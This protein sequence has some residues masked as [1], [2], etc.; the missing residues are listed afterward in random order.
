MNKIILFL[1]VGALAFSSCKPKYRICEK[2]DSP[3]SPNVVY[4]VDTNVIKDGKADLYLKCKNSSLHQSN[5][6][7]GESVKL[8]FDSVTK[9]TMIDGGYQ[10]DICPYYRADYCSDCPALGKKENIGMN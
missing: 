8:V 10:G 5:F 7:C 4:P 1:A 2:C 6:V 9:E 3:S